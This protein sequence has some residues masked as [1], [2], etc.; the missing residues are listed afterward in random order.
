M[1][2]LTVP[3]PFASAILA[4]AIRHV[5]GAQ[6]IAY[7]TNFILH[8]IELKMTSLTKSRLIDELSEIWPE[9]ADSHPTGC[10]IGQGAVMRSVEPDSPYVKKYPYVKGPHVWM[11]GQM[12][13]TKRVI[14]RPMRKQ[15]RWW[16]A[17]RW[18]E[19]ATEP[20]PI[21]P[22]NCHCGSGLRANVMNAYGNQLECLRCADLECF[23]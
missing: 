19:L 7:Q 10:I 20:E 1:N 22:K 18:L 14:I 5:N 13:P 3:Q 16:W 23:Q 12:R 15:R 21:P 6:H 11:I 8:A 17:P 9:A 2:V 4:G